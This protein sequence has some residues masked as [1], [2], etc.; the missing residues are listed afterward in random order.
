[1]PWA[2]L[3]TIL[4]AEVWW[5]GRSDPGGPTP[6]GARREPRQVRADQN[7]AIARAASRRRGRAVRWGLACGLGVALLGPPALDASAQA[8]PGFV[9]VPGHAYREFLGAPTPVSGHALVGVALVPT[10]SDL[11]QDT[12]HVYFPQTYRGEVKVELTTADGYLRGEGTFAGE[13]PAESW[14][15]LS[16]AIARDGAIR[17]ARRRGGPETLA[18]AVRSKLLDPTGQDPTARK[19]PD[20][21]HVVAWGATPPDRSRA[22]LRLYVNGRRGDMFVHLDAASPPVAC[23]RISGVTPVRFDG[24]C[25]LQADRLRGGALTLIR[26]DG[27][28]RDSLPVLLSW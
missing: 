24:I 7:H 5:R 12:L 6:T 2:P 4:G 1:M 28:D 21:L 10:P 9:P 19:T 17:T 22:T 27:F 16:I 3:G 25:D 26:R 11:T 13:A 14:V 20:R 23:R 18:V 15:P 8:R